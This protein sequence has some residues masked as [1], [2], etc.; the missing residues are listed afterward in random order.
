MAISNL[1]WGGGRKLIV[2]VKRYCQ[3]TSTEYSRNSERG[4]RAKKSSTAIMAN[5]S[6]FPE[7][8]L[9]FTR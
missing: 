6:T 5:K 2:L 8:S 4:S 9:F 1:F 7:D 3:Y